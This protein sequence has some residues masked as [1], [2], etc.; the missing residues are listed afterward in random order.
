MMIHRDLVQMDAGRVTIWGV[1]R[2]K[3]PPL[4]AGMVTGL[5]ALILGAGG[6]C[7]WLIWLIFR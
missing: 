7:L 4:V 5:L 2:K 6:F 1:P 3:L